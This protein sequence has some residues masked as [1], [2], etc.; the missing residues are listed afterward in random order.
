MK[1]T[2]SVS[3]RPKT[4]AASSRAVLAAPGG[5][6]STN[7]G[8]SSFSLVTWY[9]VTPS[10]RKIN[11]LKV[12]H[13]LASGLRRRGCGLISIMA[14]IKTTPAVPRSSVHR[15][16]SPFFDRV[17]SRFVQWRAAGAR[18]GEWQVIKYWRT[19]IRLIFCLSSVVYYLYYL[20]LTIISNITTLFKCMDECIGWRQFIWKTNQCSKYLYVV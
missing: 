4:R 12:L 13:E 15:K 5:F 18:L 14:F 1:N 20:W 6:N 16:R 17:G 10:A 8:S 9:Y 11:P 19:E 2:H 3:H 7:T